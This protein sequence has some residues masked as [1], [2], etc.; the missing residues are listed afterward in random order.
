[1]SATN[2]AQIVFENDYQ[3]AV[4]EIV[5][6]TSDNNGG[7]VKLVDSWVAGASFLAYFDLNSQEL[8]QGDGKITWLLSEE[9]IKTLS[10]D[11][12]YFFKDGTIYHLQVRELKDK[13]VPEGFLPS[14]ANQWMLVKVIEENYPNLPLEE[15]LTTYR[16]PVIIEDEKLGSF[17]LNKDLDLFQGN[18]FWLQKPI[19]LYL[20]VNAANKAT[21]TKALN[22][23]KK[24]FDRQMEEEQNWKLFAY[25]KLLE[26][27]DEWQD[28]QEKPKLS[29]ESFCQR[30]KLSSLSVSSSGKIKAYFEDD[31][32]FWGHQIKVSGNL[33]KGLLDADLVG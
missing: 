5:V 1:M 7:A 30:V 27:N 15:V 17:Q 18:A 20:E 21:W 13:S 6:L 19:A 24:L 33:K 8:I 25:Q 11:W 16:K 12:P 26:T 3:S 28:D 32:I 23:M 14:V 4:R 2:P 31:D 10:V 22:Q 9:E 29:L